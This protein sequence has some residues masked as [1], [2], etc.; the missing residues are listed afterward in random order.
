[1]TYQVPW[2]SLLIWLPVIGGCILLF[3]TGEKKQA[4][5]K[6]FALTVAMA[7]FLLTIPVYLAFDNTTAALQ[8][9]ERDI[10]FDSINIEYFL[11]VDGFSLPLIML[12]SFIA[13]IVVIAAWRSIE[14]RMAM[15]L[16][17]FLIMS[18]LMNGV[19]AS[20]DAILFYVFW[21]AMLIPMF[22]I[23]GI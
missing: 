20:A 6:W 18:G 15:Y 17:A 7:T 16:A 12:T 22:L 4:F 11:G 23:I 19:F 9:I 8:F 2:L 3:S 1:M 14:H 13:V 5:S 10:W 21:E